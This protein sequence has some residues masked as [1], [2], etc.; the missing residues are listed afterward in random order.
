MVP[1]RD[2]FDPDGSEAIPVD[3]DLGRAFLYARYDALMDQPGLRELGLE[4]LDAEKV[5]PLDAVDA[6]DDLRAIGEAIGSNL[7]LDHFG[8]FADPTALPLAERLW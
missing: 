8:M 2:P 5:S 6:I 4:H 1:R 7:S 3:E